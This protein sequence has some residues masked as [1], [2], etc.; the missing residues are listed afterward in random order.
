MVR[1]ISLQNKY[2]YFLKSSNS[3]FLND[4]YG[5]PSHVLTCRIIHSDASDD[6]DVPD[7]AFD[8]YGASSSA[9]SESN[10]WEVGSRWMLINNL[11]TQ[12]LP[13]IYAV[14]NTWWTQWSLYE[15]GMPGFD[16]LGPVDN[17]DLFDRGGKVKRPLG[18]E[19]YVRVPLAA[20]HLLKT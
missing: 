19:S 7:V 5:A 18:S 4:R 17:S 2:Y 16:D 13:S 10:D 20:L 8:L 12:N 3:W 14:S 1:T 6:S 9:I 15:D 11:I